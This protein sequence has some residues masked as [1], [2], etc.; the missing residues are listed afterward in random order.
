MLRSS[1]S[2]AQS[3]PWWPEG[4][5]THVENEEEIPSGTEPGGEDDDDF[6]DGDGQEDFGNDSGLPVADPVLP[7]QQPYISHALDH[8]FNTDASMNTG[9]SAVVQ[10]NNAD[11]IGSPVPV[12]DNLE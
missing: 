2:R 1:T 10:V 8:V 12:G 4:I 9:M 5:A 7:E 3:K 11:S 6:D